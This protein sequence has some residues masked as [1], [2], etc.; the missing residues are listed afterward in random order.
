MHLRV[1]RLLPEQTL[2][3]EAETSSLFELMATFDD[4]PTYQGLLG[5]VHH[6]RTAPLETKLNIA[7]KLMRVLFGKTDAPA[8]FAKQIGWQECLA[9]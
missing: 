8:K 3:S 9:R 1:K 7:R 6:L 2:D 5:L 4:G